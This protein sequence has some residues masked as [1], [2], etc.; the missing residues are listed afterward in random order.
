[1]DSCICQTSTASPAEPG[2]LFFVL[3]GRRKIASMRLLS[4]YSGTGMLKCPAMHCQVPLWRI[5]VSVYRPRCSKGLP[6]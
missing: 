5:Q 2:G 6:L 1:M 4:R 3:A